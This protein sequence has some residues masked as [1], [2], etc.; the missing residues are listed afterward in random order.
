MFPEL[1]RELVG[2]QLLKVALCCPFRRSE[3]PREEG[4]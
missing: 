2:L 4:G 3:R 1:L